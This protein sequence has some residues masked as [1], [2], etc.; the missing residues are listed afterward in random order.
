[1]ELKI[2]VFDNSRF[3]TLV[4]SVVLVTN[5]KSDVISFGCATDFDG[6]CSIKIPKNFNE[7]SLNVSYSLN[8]VLNTT[9]KMT[10]DMTINVY[11][12]CIIF[13]QVTD[14]C[15][16]YE[17]TDKMTLKI[18]QKDKNGILIRFPQAKSKYKGFLQID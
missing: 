8:A 5:T 11:L 1:M 13:N 15:L 18:R 14:G 9:F 16:T 7:I 2:R 17:E 4:G 10:Q 6:S 3:D 12:S